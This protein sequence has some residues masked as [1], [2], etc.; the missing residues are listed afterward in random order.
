MLSFSA[1]VF[2]GAVIGQI[3]M[4]FL[5]DVLGRSMGLA[6]TMSIATLASLLSAA[7]P[8]GDP[9]DIYAAIIVCRLFL[10]IGIGGVF[11]ISAVKASEDSGSD[12][13]VNPVSASWSFF[14]QMPAIVAPWLLAYILTFTSIST[15]SN[16]RLILGSGAIPS[17]LVVL[18]LFYENHYAVTETNSL[19]DHQATGEAREE[20]SVTRDTLVSLR[21]ALTKR[22]IYLKL[23][24]SGGSWFLFDIVVYGVTLF[25]GDI[26]NAITIEDDVSSTEDVRNTSKYQIIAS[27]LAIPGLSCRLLRHFCL[28]RSFMKVFLV[29]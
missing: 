1:V 6:L 22:E 14:Y 4:G 11:P 15:T 9:A 21:K 2:V 5:G 29:Q 13:K 25:G 8:A 26:V 18:G 3:S 24:A 16:W 23:L 27:V 28:L 20:S 17:G 10:G 19:K 7:A 12:G